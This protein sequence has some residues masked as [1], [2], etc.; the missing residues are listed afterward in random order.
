[1]P[2]SD[3]LTIDVDG[4]AVTRQPRQE[5]PEP[6]RTEPTVEVA[7]DAAFSHP[8][9][10]LAESQRA[11]EKSE[12][13]REAAQSE[14]QRHVFNLAAIVATLLSFLVSWLLF[15]NESTR[16]WIGLL[17]F[18]FGLF[19]LLK[20]IVTE[21]TFSRQLPVRDGAHHLSGPFRS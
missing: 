4:E 17:Y 2:P 16:P 5:R 14:A 19:L 7:T 20:P 13:E 8:D 18:A 6:E 12:R 3:S 1:M 9:D 21:P 15:G 10:L 11:L